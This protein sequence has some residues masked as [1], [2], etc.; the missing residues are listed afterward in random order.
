MRRHEDTQWSS[1][2]ARVAPHNP[3]E[4][5]VVLELFVP[6]QPKRLPDA[7]NSFALDSPGIGRSRRTLSQP[8]SP[9]HPLFSSVP[10]LDFARRIVP[11]SA[12]LLLWGGP[13]AAEPPVIPIGLDAYRQWERWPEERIGVHAYMRSTYDRK[14]GNERDDASHYLYQLAED[15]DVTIDVA[16]RAVL[17]PL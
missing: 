15:K 3:R 4:M 6:R 12:A 14:G 1:V 10:F 7:T 17:C 11:L 2:V 13:L 9:S 16:G 5:G 8:A